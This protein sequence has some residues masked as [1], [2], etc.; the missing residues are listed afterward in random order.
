MPLVAQSKH[1][2]IM[3]INVKMHF[4]SISKVIIGKM[5]RCHESANSDYLFF[6]GNLNSFFHVRLCDACNCVPT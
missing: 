3:S 5:S 2:T 6:K 1:I 4:I